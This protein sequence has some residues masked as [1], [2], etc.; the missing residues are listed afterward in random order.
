MPERVLKV[1]ATV[2]PI[3]EAPAIIRIEINEAIIAY[4]IAVAAESSRKKLVTR[5]FMLCS[6]VQRK[7]V[8][9]VRDCRVR[10]KQFCSRQRGILSIGRLLVT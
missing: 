2:L 6:V 5:P 4:S 9:F 3:E 10:T 7:A 1:E 8:R